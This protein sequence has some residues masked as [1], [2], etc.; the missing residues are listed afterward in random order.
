MDVITEE[1]LNSLDSYIASIMPTPSL[2]DQSFDFVVF[3]VKV[4]P[5]GVGGFVG[6]QQEPYGAV[7]GRRIVA[8][9]EI[10]IVSHETN[11]NESVNTVTQTLLAQDKRV[12]RTNGL[13][14]LAL[15][16]LGDASF[17]G[18]GG[19]ISATRVAKFDVLFEYLKGPDAADGVIS[20]VGIDLDLVVSAKAVR[21]L[22]N[23]AFSQTLFDR[24]EI[25]DD[26]QA[27]TSAP[28][29]W[30]FNDAEG[31]L[32][33]LK[34]IR[35][36]G[37]TTATAKKAGTYLLQPVETTFPV[38]AD[39]ILEAEMEYGAAD[40]NGDGIGFVFRR[41]DS[42]N[43]YFFIMSERHGY[44]MFGKKIAGDFFFL[45]TDGLDNG[46]GYTGETR[47]QVKLT[48]AGPRFDLYLDDAP[49][50]TGFDE[51]IQTAGRIGL[52]CHGNDA[53]YFYG[54]KMLGFL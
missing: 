40:G 13:F 25:D 35:G 54:I 22:V 3:P 51:S 8:S 38:T 31:R 36:G 33:Q 16:E 26:D 50:L 6:M 43:F 4:S 20:D 5:V 19:N 21:F 49:V 41:Q 34:K 7:Q 53:A 29:D 14:R 18:Q 9:A 1:A 28:S 15:N 39:F 46:N 12:M 30:Q 32:E 2:P 44:R 27:I 10:S 48:A 23:S 47:Y 45:D 52:M 17:S 37:L 11:I 24:F 42:D